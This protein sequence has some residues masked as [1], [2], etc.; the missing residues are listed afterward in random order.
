MFSNATS[1]LDATSTASVY[2]RALGD[3]FASLPS[4]LRAYFG[5]IPPGYE[6]VGAGVF[7]EA[8]LRFRILRPAFALAARLGI[9]FPERGVDVAFDVCNAPAID[10][11]RRGIRRFRFGAAT[12][13]MI[14]RMDVI[15]GRLV[16]RL[17]RGGLL[18]V[19]LDAHVRE[20]SVRLS[21]RRLALRVRNRRVPLP[22]VMRVEVVEEVV[23]G[24]PGGQ[25]VTVRVSAPVLGEIYGYR[26]VFSY[27]VIRRAESGSRPAAR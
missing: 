5:P 12:R 14:D 26:G 2:E 9:A 16:D 13:V 7:E 18:E 1:A 11:S 23:D 22:R 25:A 24:P 21:S 17:G 20:N 3:A 6:G 8:G 4:Q 19:E 27:A 10:G 15:G